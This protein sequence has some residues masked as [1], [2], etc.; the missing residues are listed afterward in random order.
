MWSVVSVHRGEGKLRIDQDCD[1]EDDFSHAF[2]AQDRR[3]ALS[4]RFCRW[5]TGTCRQDTVI[6]DAD[7]DEYSIR[8]SRYNNCKTL[9]SVGREGAIEQPE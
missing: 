8:I 4:H 3:L 2:G 1:L 9:K 5:A 7:I 6:F